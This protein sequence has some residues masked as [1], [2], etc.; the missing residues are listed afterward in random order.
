MP[1]AQ[2]VENSRSVEKASGQDEHTCLPAGREDS[3]RTEGH[4]E[5]EGFYWKEQKQKHHHITCRD[6]APQKNAGSLPTGRQAPD[7][8]DLADKIAKSC[9]QGTCRVPTNVSFFPLFVIFLSI[10][11]NSPSVALRVLCAVTVSGSR[12]PSSGRVE[13]LCVRLVPE[14]FQNGGC[15][16]K[17]SCPGPSQ[18]EDFPRPGRLTLSLRCSRFST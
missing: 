7:D 4:G 18:F 2:P 15:L 8:D 17:G 3:E 14:S 13:R 1:K 12:C 9:H 10:H 11:T 16:T 6:T 5:K